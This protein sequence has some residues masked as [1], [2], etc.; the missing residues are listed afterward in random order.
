MLLSC[1]SRPRSSCMSKYSE[2]SSSY[3]TLRFSMLLATFS[4]ISWSSMSFALA[5]ADVEGISSSA[6]FRATACQGV[7]LLGTLKPK[8]QSLF[9]PSMLLSLPNV[10]N[11]HNSIFIGEWLVLSFDPPDPPIF[12]YK[13]QFFMFFP[14]HI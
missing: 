9:L 3:C 2:D 4:I 8:S 1:L 11:F 12:F 5:T 14:L 13:Y 7:G 6:L 10:L